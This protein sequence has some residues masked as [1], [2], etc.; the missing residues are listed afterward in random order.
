MW[1]DGRSPVY[2]TAEEL[3]ETLSQLESA[4]GKLAYSSREDVARIPSLLDRAY[5]LLEQLLRAGAEVEAEQV[6]FETASR[7]LRSKGPLFLRK[8]GGAAA[9]Q[10]AR[11]T[12]PPDEHRW[13]WY[14]DREVAGQRWQ[15]LRRAG[16]MLLAAVVIFALLSALYVRLLAPDPKL[17]QMLTYQRQAEQLALSGDYEAALEAIN[18]ALGLVPDD[19]E[20]LVLKGALEVILGQMDEADAAFAAAEQLYGDRE[21]FLATRG[22][23]YIYLSELELAMADAQALLDLNPKSAYGYYLEGQVHQSRREFRAAQDSYELAS[24]LAHQSGDAELE[25][26][27]RVHLADLIIQYSPGASQPGE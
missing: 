14:I 10:A 5:D 4:L 26:L 25:A 7:Q 18:L 15:Q 6:R 1:M 27:I 17:V 20:S 12:P 23:T 16:W 3:R 2:T 8:I 13:W 9:L 21:T 19:A 11:S 22:Q 24:T